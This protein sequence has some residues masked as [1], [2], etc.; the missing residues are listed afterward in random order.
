MIIKQLESLVASKQLSSY[1][2]DHRDDTGE[3]PYMRLELVFPD[4]TKLVVIPEGNR[5]GDGEERIGLYF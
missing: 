2:L 3:N 4:G 5:H 1:A